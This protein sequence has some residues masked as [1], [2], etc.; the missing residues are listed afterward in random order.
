MPPTSALN[1]HKVDLELAALLAQDP[2]P[3][4]TARPQPPVSPKHLG[5]RG[6][7]I[8]PLGPQGPC[9]PLPGPPHRAPV[10]VSTVSPSGSGTASPPLETPALQAQA[11]PAPA[12]RLPQVGSPRWVGR[13]DQ[14][15]KSGTECPPVVPVQSHT[16]WMAAASSLWT[17]RLRPWMCR[18]KSSRC[19]HC[20]GT[21][22]RG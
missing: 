9:C 14:P 22:G 12:P 15:K 10:P 1:H 8:P 7:P 2:T 16:S 20:R 6:P 13:A 17:S 18:M 4:P 19:S 11:R 5:P 3:T 21:S